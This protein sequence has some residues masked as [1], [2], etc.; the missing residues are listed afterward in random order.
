MLSDKDY[1]TWNGLIPPFLIFKAI[2]ENNLGRNEFVVLSFLSSES[3]YKRS[4]ICSLSHNEIANGTWLSVK[5]VERSLD[6]LELCGILD[7]KRQWGK[8]KQR[9]KSVYTISDKVR[10]YGNPDGGLGNPDVTL[11]SP[12]PNPLGNSDGRVTSQL[13]RKDNTKSNT[14]NNTLSTQTSPSES[15]NVPCE[16]EQCD[17]EQSTQQDDKLAKHEEIQPT[18][19]SQGKG[20]KTDI[21][22]GDCEMRDNVLGR[23]GSWSNEIKE[24]GITVEMMSEAFNVF[25]ESYPWQTDKNKTRRLFEALVWSK[26]A[27]AN[28]LIKAARNYAHSCE[29][30][31]QT[32]FKSPATFLGLD[33]PWRE[34][35]T[36]PKGTPEIEGEY[37][38]VITR[39][40]DWK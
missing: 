37:E 17:T 25:W 28:E 18:V 34:F 7:V 3:G 9:L 31:K 4:D 21:G 32:I 6:S 20:S 35:I 29:A 1:S 15:E 11:A 24:T 38:L 8:N 13:R 2:A 10:R 30:R 33:S 39:T 36:L 26:E 19:S 23:K 14:I 5:T 40:S 16:N 22:R 27:K 12:V